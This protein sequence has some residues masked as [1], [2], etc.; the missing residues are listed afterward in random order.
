MYVK[1]SFWSCSLQN[2]ITAS[3]HQSVPWGSV[4]C[5]RQCNSSVLITA[6]VCCIYRERERDNQAN[7]QLTSQTENN[8]NKDRS[9]KKS[10]LFQWWF[11]LLGWCCVTNLIG[12]APSLRI[13]RGLFGKRATHWFPNWWECSETAN[14]I[15]LFFVAFPP[16]KCT[17]ESGICGLKVTTTQESFQ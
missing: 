8:G 6:T 14:F 16:M 12:T 4:Y 5:W 10:L 3:N 11:Y 7:R 17:Q 15:G 13:A 2:M 9:W 1:K